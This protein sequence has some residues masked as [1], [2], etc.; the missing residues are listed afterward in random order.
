MD[1][2]TY[3]DI[4]VLP[5]K[6]PCGVT[7]KLKGGLLWLLCNNR[8]TQQ[9]FFPM[10]YALLSSMLNN[11]GRIFHWNKLSGKTPRASNVIKHGKNKKH[12]WL[13]EAK[14]ICSSSHCCVCAQNPQMQIY[15]AVKLGWHQQG[16]I[17][18]WQRNKKQMLETF[19]QEALL[20]FPFTFPP[21]VTLPTWMACTTE[22]PTLPR[23]T[24]GLFG[25]PGMGG[26][27][28]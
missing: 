18:D 7:G 2:Q 4:Q 26:G 11:S 28:P 13:K 19:Q 5:Y 21:G 9:Y 20:V 16:K 25:T 27:I 24:T 6:I 23:Q 8:N 14:N 1:R 12:F 10:L 15:A 22:V 17:F 3:G